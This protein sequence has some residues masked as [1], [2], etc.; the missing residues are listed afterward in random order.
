MNMELLLERLERLAIVLDE[1]MPQCAELVRDAISLLKEQ[2]D[3]SNAL[4]DQCDRV[5]RLRKELAEQP[6]IVRCKD[7]KHVCLCDTT[8]MMPDIPVY[9]KCT[10][11]DEVNDPDWFCADGEARQ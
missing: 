6:Q 4:V 7:C 3:V 11:T 1:L 10:L 8:E 5:R 2:E 9:A